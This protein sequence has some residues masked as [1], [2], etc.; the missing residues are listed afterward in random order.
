MAR[1]VILFHEPGPASSQPEHFDFMLETQ[2]Q[3]FLAT[4]RWDRIPTQSTTF[5]AIQLPPHRLA[6]LDYEGTIS[7]GLGRVTQ[8]VTGLYEKT[9]SLDDSQWQI[10]LKSHQLQGILDATCLKGTNWQ[11]RIKLN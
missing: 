2:E 6:Y 7:R 10:N 11:F 8:C 4:W 5:H 1:F 3:T 9:I